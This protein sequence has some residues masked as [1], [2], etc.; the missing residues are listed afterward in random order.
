MKK[1]LKKILSIIAIVFIA[2]IVVIVLAINIFGDQALKVGIETGASKAMKVGVNLDDISLAILGGKLN[3][4]NLVVENP[5]GY[6]NSTFLELGTCLVELNTRS[7]L[8][9][10]VEIEKMQFDNIKLTIEQKGLTSNL[11]QILD[12]LPKSEST[13]EKPA[14]AEEE[15]TGKNL[16]I[17]ELDINGIEV[18]V[19]LLPIPGRAD[20]LTLKINPIHME[21]LGT[22][23]KINTPKLVSKIL[24]AIAGGIAQQGADLL[25]MDLIN[26]IGAQLGEQGKKLLEAG[27]NVGTGIIEG[28]KDI[29]KGAT[30]VLKGLNPFKAKKEE[31]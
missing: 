19:K 6:Q 17:K 4:N 21:N 9:D 29:G 11:S 24:L 15:G 20:N 18:T 25:P 23:E 30:D 26:N 27:Q 2:L 14:V 8:S 28:G 22:A 10:T 7:L 16:L 13:E 1:G 12:N 3:M 31:E 5:E